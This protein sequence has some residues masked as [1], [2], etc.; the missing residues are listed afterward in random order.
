M[1][2]G[3]INMSEAKWIDTE[4]SGAPA[5]AAPVGVSFARNSAWAGPAATG[6]INADGTMRVQV[7]EPV[8]NNELWS[9]VYLRA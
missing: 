2:S 4:L 9:A 8:T 5:P 1:M 3:R 7:T 6:T